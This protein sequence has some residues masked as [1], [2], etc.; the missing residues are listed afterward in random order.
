MEIIRAETI[1][2]PE[3]PLRRGYSGPAVIRK[4]DVFATADGAFK[5][6]VWECVGTL[7]NENP[8]ELHQVWIVLRGRIEMTMGE[9]RIEASAGDM[10][11]LEAPYAAKTLHASKDLRIVWVSGAPVPRKSGVEQES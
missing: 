5:A 10:I 11:L 4:K 7:V 8:G 6:G 2:L 1:E 3:A 9:K